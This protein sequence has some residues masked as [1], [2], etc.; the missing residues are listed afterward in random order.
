MLMDAV[1][2]F[3]PEEHRESYSATNGQALFYRGQKNLKHK[4][5]AL[6]EEEGAQRAA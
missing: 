4:I 5:L 1:L 2:D 6:S 3:M